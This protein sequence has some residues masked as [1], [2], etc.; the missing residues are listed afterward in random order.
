MKHAET[1]AENQSATT[2][3]RDFIRGAATIAPLALAPGA[4]RSQGVVQ[5]T[6]DRFDYVIGGAGHNSLLC[7]AYLAKA[8]NR[9]IVLEG[10]TM[11]GGGVKT[12]EVLLPGFREDLCSTV[13]G[14]Y[15]RNPAYV[16][17]EID[18]ND[19]GYELMDPEI[20][21]HMPFLD[22]AS[23]TVEDLGSLNGTRLNGIE[24]VK[25]SPMTVGAGSKLAP[26]GV[27]LTVHFLGDGD[28][29]G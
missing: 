23:L 11:I 14:G 4:G 10:R 27:T 24:L 17:N 19:H 1:K 29:R 28:G 3:R 21:S 6:G 5:G 18:L 16:N 20:V 13:H 8:G 9:V 15:S 7:A 26:G 2:T 12:A 25:G 22:G